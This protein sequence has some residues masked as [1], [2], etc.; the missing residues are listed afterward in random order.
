MVGSGVLR[1]CSPRWPSK[2]SQTRTSLSAACQSRSTGRNASP[3]NPPIHWAAR[4]PLFGTT[5][6]ATPYQS[7][8]NSSRWRTCIPRGVRLPHT[9][10]SK[11]IRNSSLQPAREVRVAWCA[12]NASCGPLLRWPSPLGAR[13]PPHAGAAPVRRADGRAGR[14]PD[15]ASAPPRFGRW[16][17]RSED[18]PR[19][20]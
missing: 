4:T 10:P 20:I 5:A 19:G 6:T 16:K 2:P 12:R 14:V 17:E 3:L 7:R 13:G 15:G 18:G 8:D 1:A 11:P 9:V